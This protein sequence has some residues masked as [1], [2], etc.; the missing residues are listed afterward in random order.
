[1]EAEK[2]L[3][4]SVDAATKVGR[5]LIKSLA[6][7]KAS[8]TGI[9]CK[10][11]TEGGVEAVFSVMGFYQTVLIPIEIIPFLMSLYMYQRE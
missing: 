9:V 7:E 4:Q 2:N 11:P 8:K 3:D 5:F 10:K 1:M 6:T